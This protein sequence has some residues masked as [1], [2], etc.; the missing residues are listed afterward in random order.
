M[1]N[2]HHPVLVTVIFGLLSGLAL[3]ASSLVLSGTPFGSE[4]A[5]LVLWI[6]A[7]GYGIWLSRWTGSSLFSVFFPLFFL[8]LT[9]FFVASTVAF[10]FLALACMSWVRSQICFS[11]TGRFKIWVESLLCLAGSGMVA[12]FSPATTLSWALAIWLFFLLQAVY[13]VILDHRAPVPRAKSERTPD[14]FFR[15]SRQAEEIL[16]RGGIK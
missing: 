2:R 3:I 14:S 9:A 8:G 7:A 5:R 4:A 10:Y 12:L 11:E 16:S 1:K 13:V 6:S 15:S